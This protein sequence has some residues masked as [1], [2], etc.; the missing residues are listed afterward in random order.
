MEKNQTLWTLCSLLLQIALFI[1]LKLLPFP[2]LNCHPVE[3]KCQ[4]DASCSSIQ[5]IFIRSLARSLPLS[6]LLVTCFVSCLAMSTKEGLT[7][8]K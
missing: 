6:K 4:V 5:K 3:L 2:H 1:L 8:R 7:E